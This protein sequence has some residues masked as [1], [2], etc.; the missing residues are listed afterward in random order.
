MSNYLPED[1]A[2]LEHARTDRENR[3]NDA[4]NRVDPDHLYETANAFLEILRNI[5]DCMH[6]LK[7]A[8]EVCEKWEPTEYLF[9]KQ[10]SAA[11]FFDT[12]PDMTE[13]IVRVH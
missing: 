2:R 3:V 5:S 1:I 7:R 12:H 13:A 6:K 8:D 11:R 9:L 4:E 10:K